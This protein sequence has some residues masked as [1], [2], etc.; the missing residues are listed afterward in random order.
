M[1]DRE[2]AAMEYERFLEG[3][4]DDI[5]SDY[6]DELEVPDVLCERDDSHG[7]ATNDIGGHF[8]CDDCAEE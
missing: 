2:A 4:D 7:K 1:Q 6:E 3:D 8:L 5:E